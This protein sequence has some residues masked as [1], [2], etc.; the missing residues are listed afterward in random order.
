MIPGLPLTTAIDSSRTARAA[1]CAA[2]AGPRSSRTVCRTGESGGLVQHGLLHAG[3]VERAGGS[4]GLE[5]HAQLLPQLGTLATAQEELTTAQHAVRSGIAELCANAPGTI[6]R[7]MA[8]VDEVLAVIYAHRD[9]TL[10]EFSVVC[11][12][13]TK[14]LQAQTDELEVSAGQLSACVAQG[15]AA[16]ARVIPLSTEQVLGTAQSML[17]L[18]QP[19]VFLRE[20]VQLDIL[21]HPEPV[22]VAVAELSKLCLHVVD[23]TKTSATGGGLV[24]FNR[25]AASVVTLACKDGNGLPA[26]WVTAADVALSVSTAEGGRA[27]HLNTVT[28]STPGVVELTYV[29]EDEGVM[30]VELSASVCG[31]AV[32]GGPWTARRVC[33]GVYVAKI[34]V[35]HTGVC[36]LAVTSDGSLMVLGNPYRHE[37]SVY[38]I[39][40]GSLVRSFG[41]LGAAAGQFSVPARICMT[42]HDTVLVAEIRNQRVQEV[43]L[44]G[45][46]V[47][48]FG[49]GV[50]QQAVYSVAAH[51]DVMAV[52]TEPSHVY[53]FSYTTGILLRQ[54]GLTEDP[55]SVFCSM[56]FLRDGKH[57]VL[58]GSAGVAVWTVEGVFARPIGVGILGRRPLD[59][60]VTSAGEVVVLDT[61]NHRVCV[62]SP[63]DDTLS[64]TWGCLGGGDGQFEYPAAVAANGSQ[65]YV[66]DPDNTRLQ[67][68]E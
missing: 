48:Y 59:L 39:S 25:S 14:V 29:V 11:A 13:R 38:R 58:T 27:G 9:K 19:V 43:T 34:R 49:V 55:E 8:A 12:E 2:L 56:Q 47:R 30:E 33:Q 36:S 51:D 37:L 62:F 42:V 61:S 18:G 60:A 66:F 65:V 16:V 32:A 68:F 22:Q 20:P 5:D 45:E 4:P 50:F 46:H 52:G 63:A 64:R 31:A 41:S 40:D 53:L 1:S 7:F 17:V 44:E 21:V 67:V 15:R 57:L 26:F 3:T 54:F 23:G 28:V 24:A 6:S 35:W 10:D